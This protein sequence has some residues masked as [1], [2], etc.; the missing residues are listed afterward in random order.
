MNFNFENENHSKKE[1]KKENNL[2]TLVDSVI[3]NVFIFYKMATQKSHIK[4]SSRSNPMF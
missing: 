2:L 1:N 3:E 4:T